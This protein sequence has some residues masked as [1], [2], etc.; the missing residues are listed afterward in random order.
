MT[1]PDTKLDA[2]ASIAATA[3]RLILS[4]SALTLAT[5]LHVPSA[6]AACI[7]SCPC[8]RVS[9]EP[10]KGG[11]YVQHRAGNAASQTVPTSKPTSNRYATASKIATEL[12]RKASKGIDDCSAKL[13]NKPLV[14]C[15]MG[16]L[17][18]LRKGLQK[19]ATTRETMPDTIA[20]VDAGVRDV[21]GQMA[22]LQSVTPAIKGQIVSMVEKAKLVVEN[23]LLTVRKAGKKPIAALSDGLAAISDVLGKAIA[24]IQLKGDAVAT[25]VAST[26]P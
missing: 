21:N 5:V 25:G 3:A 18:E 9:S 10:R 16:S 26:Q 8:I 24:A 14:D 6:A 12:A 4:G 22:N 13:V 1:K 2:G 7:G 23:A 15:I 17:D 11:V 19:N 20:A